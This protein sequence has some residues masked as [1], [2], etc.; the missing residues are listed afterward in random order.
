MAA[1]HELRRELPI[2][3]D[4]AVVDDGDRA[5]LVVDR[6]LAAGDVDDGEPPHRE[7]DAGL[8]VK[9]VAIGPAM[10]DC[11]V[12]PLQA[13]ARSIGSEPARSKYPVMPHMRDF[14]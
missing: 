1:A 9:A 11:V 6:L 7:A 8:E 4:L 5:V 14:R 3:V 2:V 13:R 10:G 12:H